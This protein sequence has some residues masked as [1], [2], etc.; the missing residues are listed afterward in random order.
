MILGAFLLFFGAL[1]AVFAGYIAREYMRDRADRDRV[2]VSSAYDVRDATVPT[3]KLPA[4]P[5]PEVPRPGGFIEYEVVRPPKSLRYRYGTPGDTGPAPFEYHLGLVPQDPPAGDEDPGPARLPE[6][7][8]PPAVAPA[9]D[10]GPGNLPPIT[11]QVVYHPASP[12]ERNAAAMAAV[13]A[14][15]GGE[16]MEQLEQ[17]TGYS[18][19]RPFTDWERDSVVMPAIKDGA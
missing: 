14:L 12:L 5:F 13:K 9:G 4:C 19:S 2:T 1:F 15:T 10:T 18:A 17:D 3:R 6:G 11:G 7:D 8:T 16:Y